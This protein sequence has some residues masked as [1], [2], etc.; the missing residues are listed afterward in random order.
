MKKLLPLGLAALL[1]GCSL[2]APYTLTF[3]NAPGSVVDPASSTLDL[4]VSD[5]VLAYISKIECEGADTIALLPIMEEGAT[6][7]TVHKL[8]LTAM[9]DM[10]AGAACEVTVTV[11]DPTTTEQAEGSIEVT[12]AGEP[13]VTEEDTEEEEA[14]AEE[15]SEENTSVEA[16]VEAT[17]ETS[18][19][20]PIETHE[21]NASESAD[22]AGTNQ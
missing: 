11:Y 2:V 14:P 10:P 22:A 9:K 21:S 15:T 1:A 3:T 17:V 16:S 5:P 18:T 8:S 4:V 7:N 12:M 13:V 19:E 6:T 20:T